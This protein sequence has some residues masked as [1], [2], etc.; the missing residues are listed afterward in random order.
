MAN[1]CSVPL[2]YIFLRGQGIKIFS[3]VAKECREKNYLLPVLE[4]VESKEKTEKHTEKQDIL[5][6]NGETKKSERKQRKTQK[7]HKS[8]KSVGTK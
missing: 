4:R 8:E 3:L 2:S 7:T 6:K 1:V 5:Q